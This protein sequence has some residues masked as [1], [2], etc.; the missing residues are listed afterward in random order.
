MIRKTQ[1]KFPFVMNPLKSKFRGSQHVQ[2]LR[3]PEAYVEG[4]LH[5]QRG[6]VPEFDSH[7]EDEGED[8]VQFRGFGVDRP[9]EDLRG[10]QPRREAGE[11]HARAERGG[12]E[13][14]GFER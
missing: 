14:M 8:T 12:K 7:E 9:G 6:G 11:V 10:L 1:E 4:Y 13:A 5:L 2:V 3:N